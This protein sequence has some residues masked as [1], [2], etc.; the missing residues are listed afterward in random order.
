MA[1]PLRWGKRKGKKQLVKTHHRWQYEIAPIIHR[2]HCKKH[3]LD[4]T[5]LVG[6][7][8][9]GV[10]F[11]CPGFGDDQRHIFVIPYPPKKAAEHDNPDK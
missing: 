11:R 6:C 2:A 7:V 10:T 3:N 9:T 5:D 4:S 1:S 8:P